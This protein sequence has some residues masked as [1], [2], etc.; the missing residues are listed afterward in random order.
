MGK[1]SKPLEST[2]DSIYLE[3]TKTVLKI[4]K[5]ERFTFLAN[6]SPIPIERELWSHWVSVVAAAYHPHGWMSL[7]MKPCSACFKFVFLPMVI[8][9]LFSYSSWNL[10]CQSYLIPRVEIYIFLSEKGTKLSQ[11]LENKPIGILDL[12]AMLILQLSCSVS[13]NSR[14]SLITAFLS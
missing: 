2:M 3:S 8:D 12:L 13:L 4:W 9:L 6:N 14:Q 7:R 1:F 11:G 5:I 10:L